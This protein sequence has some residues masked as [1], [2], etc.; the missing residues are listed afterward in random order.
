MWDFFKYAGRMAIEDTDRSVTYDEVGNFCRNFTVRYDFFKKNNRTLTLIITDNSINCIM[1][2]AACVENRTP[3]LLVNENLTEDILAGIVCKYEPSV[4]FDFSGK[5]CKTDYFVV[6]EK[7]K[8]SIHP[9]LALLLLTSGSTGNS[10]AVR[11]SY[12]NLYSNM[13][14][15]SESLDIVSSDRAALM[16]PMS[17]SYGLS[18]INSN[19]YSGAAIIKSL[20]I[21]DPGLAKYLAGKK[22]T[23]V[24][25]VPLT[26]RF[27][28]KIKFN[29]RKII[30]LRLITQAGG[31]LDSE[32]KMWLCESSG[33]ST[34]IAVMYGQTEAT[35]RMTCF[36]LNRHPEK[37]DSAGQAIPGGKIEISEAGEIFYYGRN[38]FMGYADSCKD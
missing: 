26:Y 10:K 25:G 9:D 22:V 13:K 2:Y 17:Y 7:Q 36:Y 27:L 19:F 3:V 32:T 37:K 35:E 30:N 14:S 31:A 18:V 20:K 28:K 6:R 8:Y 29:F 24:C 5:I 38:V 1:T 16:L 12:E 23:S 33:K 15:I 34:D 4:I 11:L 21:T